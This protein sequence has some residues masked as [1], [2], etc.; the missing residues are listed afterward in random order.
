M[1][2][3]TLPFF[4]YYG[5]LILATSAI[6]DAYLSKYNFLVSPDPGRKN[7]DSLKTVSFTPSLGDDCISGSPVHVY[8]RNKKHID[9]QEEVH[10]RNVETYCM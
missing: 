10:K 2:L 1:K 8:D 9:I 7:W 4:F 6:F 3:H 5:L